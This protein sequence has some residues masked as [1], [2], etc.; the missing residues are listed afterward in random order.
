[1]PEIDYAALSEKCSS[2]THASKEA[3]IN[4]VLQEGGIVLGV[5]LPL[6]VPF[7]RN[8]ASEFSRKNDIDVIPAD[9]FFTWVEEWGQSKQISRMPT[10]T[11]PP[12]KP[13]KGLQTQGS[14]ATLETCK[15][16]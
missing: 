8:K 6:F 3:E 9:K 7:F 12:A 11:R 5:L 2:L 1:M 16:P 14:A 10:P 15:M 13:A 4:E